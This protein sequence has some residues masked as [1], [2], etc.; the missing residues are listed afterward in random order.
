MTILSLFLVSLLTRGVFLFFGHP[1]ITNDE[2]DY[3]MNGYLLAKTGSDIFGNKFFLTSGILFSTSAVPIYIVGLFLTFFNKSIV[4]GRLP[5]ALLNS[6]IPVLFYLLIKKLTR[7]TKLSLIGF[8]VLNF[9]PWFSYLSSQSAI[10]APFSL[11]FFLIA[12]IIILE[13][14]IGHRLKTLLFLFFLFLSFNS[15]MGMKTIFFPLVVTLLI[16]KDF[17]YHKKINVHTVLLNGIA[18]F[19]LF[20]SFTLL[21]VVLP[22]GPYFTSRMKD[23][24]LL[25]NAEPIKNEVIKHIYFAEGPLILKRLLFNKASIA[26]TL[27][28][29]RY[30]TAFNPLLLFFKGDPHPL[31]GT[32]LFGLFYLFDFFF[33]LIGIF[34][35]KN[36]LRG[37]TTK[38]VY[39]FLALFF[40]FPLP[41]AFSK[42][43]PTLALRGFGL[44]FPYSFFIAIGLYAFFNRYIRKRWMIMPIIVFLY[45]FSFVYFFV[46]FQTEIKFGS[47][48]QWHYSEKILADK[49]EILAKKEIQKRIIIYV[50]EPRESLL[51]YYFYKERN[52]FKIKAGLLNRKEYTI[53]NVSFVSACPSEKIE[54][55]IQIV[56]E[57]RCNLNLEK[58]HPA[59]FISSRNKSG[60]SYYILE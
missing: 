60:P 31:Y 8:F 19:F 36:F 3:Y 55:T 52:P 21:L 26:L 17:Y 1:S 57:F 22:N 16:A 9:S 29:E 39:F 50:N 58:L 24:I 18:A 44:L 47:G 34:S 32:N 45:F 12:A 33:L 14:R 4:V 59:E 10:D 46:R 42:N 51:L 53:H 40:I 6:F 54:N 37:Q 43:D 49:I 15:Y 25:F 20:L 7:N 11:L 48:E 28:F 23:E 13:K 5:F 35:L 2:A 41:I 38:A 27:Y 56:K 30:L